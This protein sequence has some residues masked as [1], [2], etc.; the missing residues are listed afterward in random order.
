MRKRLA[1]LNERFAAKGY[2]QLN[3]GIGI[4]AGEVT[5]GYLG[6]E[7]RLEFTVIGA[8]VNLAARI[9]QETRQQNRAILFSEAFANKLPDYFKSD[10][11][12]EVS[13]KGI[14]LPVRLYSP[15]R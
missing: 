3:N 12:A 2:P 10:F 6:S 7:E 11:V 15:G 5:A 1:E 4:H 14:S 8:P 9:E 13:L